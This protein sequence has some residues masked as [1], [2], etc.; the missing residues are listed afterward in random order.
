MPA[1]LSPY[2]Q[3]VEAAEALLP[4]LPPE[5]FDT[6]PGSP[7]GPPLPPLPLTSVLA[8]TRTSADAPSDTTAYDEPPDVPPWPPLDP[9]EP[10]PHLPGVPCTVFIVAL[11]AEPV[12]T[13]GSPP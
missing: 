3:T 9:P 6:V 12:S 13:H 5:G 10:H 4:M 2:A 8:W 7:P 11:H 1:S